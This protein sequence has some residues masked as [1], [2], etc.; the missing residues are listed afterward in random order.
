[1]TKTITTKKEKIDGNSGVYAPIFSSRISKTITTKK[2]KIDGKIG[3][4]A[5]ILS[6]R[7]YKKGTTTKEN[8]EVPAA[9][10]H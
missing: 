4:N 1:M 8:Q 2:E 6:S 5:P 7:K 3:V 9:F 10:T